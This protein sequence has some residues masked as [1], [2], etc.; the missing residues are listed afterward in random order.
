MTD[1]G[2]RREQREHSCIFCE[3]TRGDA[4][5]SIIRENDSTMSLMSLEGTPIVIPKKHIVSPVED[6]ELAS[7]VFNEALDLS[8][9]IETVFDTKDFNILANVGKK[10]GQEVPHFHVHILPRTSNDNLMRIS[11][12]PPYQREVLDDLASQF[13]ER[14]AL[15][16]QNPQISE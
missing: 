14:I 12:I 5:A 9:Y 3:I 1:H 10:S 7:N 16:L 15:T 13:R 6:K 8:T 2:P 11:F 4:E